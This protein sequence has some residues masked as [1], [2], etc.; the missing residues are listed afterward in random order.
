MKATKICSVFIALLA[1]GAVACGGQGGSSN[2]KGGSSS[3]RKSSSVDTGPDYTKVLQR[4]YDDG[5]SA[6]N[7]S[8]KEYFTLVDATANKVGVK[9][10]F[11]NFTLDAPGTTATGV[12]SSGKIEP[13]NDHDA[14]IRF[15]I[16]APKAG[17]YQMVM[18]G[19][20]STSNDALSK[21]LGDRSFDVKLNGTSVDVKANRV[22][23][24][25]SQAEFV[26]VPTINLTGQEDTID[27]TASDYRIQFD[28]AG[29]VLFQ[30]Q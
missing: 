9:I 28:R 4:T 11:L 29:F 13:G 3:Q 30:E 25:D 1:M 8:N 14:Y 15:R 18:R 27:V 5:T 23:L 21:T 26:A 22:P 10:A 6:T 17:A 16:T 7:S 19:K 24:T 12:D 20:S 2:G